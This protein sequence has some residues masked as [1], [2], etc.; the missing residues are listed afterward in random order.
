MKIV[1]QAHLLSYMLLK[2]N[3][4]KHIQNHH[5]FFHFEKKGKAPLMFAF[6][7]NKVLLFEG[8]EQAHYYMDLMATASLEKRENLRLGLSG[9]EIAYD[10]FPSEAKKA[11]KEAFVAYQKSELH[12]H[13]LKHL[14]GQDPV[15]LEEAEYGMWL[16]QMETMLALV[17]A[18]LNKALVIN[19]NVPH[20]I[21][22]HYTEE[23]PEGML[24]AYPLEHFKLGR[25]RYAFDHQEV[26]DKVNDL[27]KIP[28]V[29]H[30]ERHYIDLSKNEANECVFL[31]DAVSEEVV[32]YKKNITAETLE[33]SLFDVLLAFMDTVK[34]RPELIELRDK[35]IH[36]L[37]EDFCKKADIE[38]HIIDSIPGLNRLLLSIT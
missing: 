33:Q 36:N 19:L 11:L 2:R 1:E 29:L 38:L 37:I 20:A 16:S 35:H 8:Y 31:A 17:D 7:P 13:F 25:P 12:P 32:K 21:V 15:F 22:K 34:A 30:L 10:P 23:E 26:I 3:P 18:L 9:L 24:E 4:W 6:E 5:Y 27:E 28:M 14:P